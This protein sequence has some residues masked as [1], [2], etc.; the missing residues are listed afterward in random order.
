MRLDIEN[1]RVTV[2]VDIGESRTGQVGK[3]IERMRFRYNYV[4]SGI[5]RAMV[6]DDAWSL[7]DPVYFD[8]FVSYGTVISSDQTRVD[9]V[10][11]T[12]YW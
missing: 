8:L 2:S 9:Y 7:L 10:S 6:I 12:G 1:W 4:V 3:V 11:T 5:C